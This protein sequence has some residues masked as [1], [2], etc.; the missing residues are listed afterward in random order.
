MFVEKHQARP[1]ERERAVPL[2]I[3]NCGRN[4]EVGRKNRW[5]VGGWPP[6]QVETGRMGRLPH[7][8]ELFNVSHFAL[9]AAMQLSYKGNTTHITAAATE[10]VDKIVFY[11]HT[12]DPTVEMLYRR[13]LE[14]PYHHFIVGASRQTKIR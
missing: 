3:T 1:R 7:T 5:E 2:I 6:K 8:P 4:W 12:H 11:H 10:V 14:E 9:D 13:H